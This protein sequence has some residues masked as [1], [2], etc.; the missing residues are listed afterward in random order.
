MALFAWVADETAALI[1]HTVPDVSSAVGW[2]E[3]VGKR[4]LIVPTETQISAGGVVYRNTGRGTEI[5][6]VRVG[7]R[8][9]LPKGIIDQGEETE[10]TAQREVREEAGVDAAVIG[11]IDRIEYWYYTSI[12]RGKKR[13]HKF[14]FFYLMRYISGDPA[15]HD[16]EV[17]EAGWFPLDEIETLVPFRGEAAILAKAREM[18]AAE[19]AQT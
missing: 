8:W 4:L 9:Q 2:I 16:H 3:S 10:A 15:N 6:L 13:I 1:G 19:N 12:G 7:D 18:L 14:V 11:L 5:A 17:D